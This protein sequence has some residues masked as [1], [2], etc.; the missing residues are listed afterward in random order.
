MNETPLRTLHY[1]GP[2]YGWAL[3][4]TTLLTVVLVAHHPVAGPGDIKVAIA[5][6]SGPLQW[7]HGGLM[8]LILVYAAC[9]S[10]FAWRLGI[11]QPLVMLGWLAYLAG[12]VMLLLAA[13][14]D[15]FLDGD[16]ARSGI[17]AAA[18]VL[19]LAFIAVQGLTRLG[20]VLIATATVAWGHALLHHKGGAR[21]MGLLALATGGPSAAFMLVSTGRINVETLLWYLTAQ[22]VW[23]LGVGIWMTRGLKRPE[24]L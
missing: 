17:A 2:A 10:G 23:N 18:D 15:G 7:V 20:F 1:N 13:L 16:I 8:V 22:T 4:A 11:A 5:A 19:R 6:V 9:F 24:G 3:I 21:W 12:T 14:T